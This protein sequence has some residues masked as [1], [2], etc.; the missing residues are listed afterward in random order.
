MQ[1]GVGRILRLACQKAGGTAVLAAHLEVDPVLLAGWL[2]DFD[3]PPP[4]V[5]LGAVDLLLD[6]STPQPHDVVQ[7]WIQSPCITRSTRLG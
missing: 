5:F 2:L 1:S 4:E 3:A 6:W 7:T